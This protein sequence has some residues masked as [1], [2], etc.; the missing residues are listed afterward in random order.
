VVGVAD[1]DDPPGLAVPAARGEAGVVEDR[2]EH[3]AR[4]RLVGELANGPGGAHTV[5]KSMGAG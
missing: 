5:L 1:D 4:D 3:L 2:V